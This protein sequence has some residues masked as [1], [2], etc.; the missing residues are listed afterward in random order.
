MQQ[1]SDLKHPSA[2]APSAS[3]ARAADPYQQRNIAMNLEYSEL[4]KSFHEIGTE[5]VITKSGRRMFPYCN[6][7]VS[8]LVPY[9]KYVI[10]VDMVPVDSSRYK[11]NNEQ[12]EVAGKAEPQPPCRTYVHPDSPALGSHWMKQPI[13]F[14]KLKLTNNPLDQR[15]HIILHSMHRYQPRFH[16]VQ[17]DDLYSVRWGVFQTFTFPETSFTA[18]TVYQN[19]KITKLKIDHNPFAKGF[20]EEGTHGK[21]HRAQKSQMCPE[22]SAKKLKL[23]S[24]KEPEPE[25]MT[26]SDMPRLPYDPHR[27]ESE[28]MM[29]S[30]DL[31]MAQDEHMSPWGG[32][33][34]PA[35]SLHSEGVMDYTNSEQLVPGQAS[36]QPH[37]IHEFER[38]PSPSSCVDGQVDRQSFES[39]SADMA[40]VPEQEISRPLPTMSL[41]SPQCRSLDFTMTQNIAGCSK[42]RPGLGAHPLYGH[43]NTEQPLTH[44]SGALPGQYSSPAYHHPHHLMSD[45][46][47]HP[48][49]YHHSNMAEWSQYSLFPY[50]C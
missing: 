37:R 31:P 4:W 7:S 23:T 41:G 28:G 49:G 34:D 16:V 46:S 50:S 13:S 27:D 26:Y 42:G 43:Y 36:Y 22:N 21:R 44:W 10:M 40:T 32:E 39:R 3:M 48:S 2:M 17:A 24:D 18:V 20:R 25:F 5:M 14:L 9:A 45:H 11:W 38:M 35:Q 1:M 30:K 6:I 47:L 33:Q 29:L 15:G 8:G 12:W 19:S